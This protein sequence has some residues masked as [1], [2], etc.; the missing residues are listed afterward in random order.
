MREHPAYVATC[1]LC[2]TGHCDE[3]YI[4]FLRAEVERQR[5]RELGH[6]NTMKLQREEVKRLRAEKERCQ[7]GWD[8]AWKDADTAEAEVER[9]QAKLNPRPGFGHQG[10]TCKEVEAKVERLRV[11]NEELHRVAEQATERGM[12]AEAEAAGAG[13]LLDVKEAEVKRL[14]GSKA[15]NGAISENAVDILEVAEAEEDACR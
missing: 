9:L 8:R 12:A 13:M 15:P 7:A 5:E 6:L 10:N 11:E 2:A 14:R 1:G 4:E 3:H